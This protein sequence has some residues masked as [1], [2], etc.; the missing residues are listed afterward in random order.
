ME[1]TKP[2]SQ[3][4][5]M[6]D[7]LAG[8][9]GRAGWAADPCGTRSPGHATP[10]NTVDPPTASLQHP[11]RFLQPLA[12]SWQHLPRDQL[13]SPAA[14]QPLPWRGLD[15]VKMEQHGI[16][17]KRRENCLLKPGNS[18]NQMHLCTKQQRAKGVVVRACPG[19]S[20]AGRRRTRHAGHSGE[21]MERADRKGMPVMETARAKP[22]LRVGTAARGGMGVS[23]L[24]NLGVNCLPSPAFPARKGLL[25][26]TQG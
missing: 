15:L 14:A 16:H 6:G 13:I 24:P 8:T 18:Q 20:G 10:L 19:S 17:R 7:S 1:S 5:G 11:Q 25:S 22:Q 21:V 26:S 23:F 3:S 4:T 9:R 2:C 12:T